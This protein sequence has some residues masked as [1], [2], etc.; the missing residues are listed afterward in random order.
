MSSLVAGP[1]LAEIDKLTG[2]LLVP[3]YLSSHINC[4]R[5]LSS[6][7]FL[8]LAF[9][10]SPLDSKTSGFLDDLPTL[11]RNRLGFRG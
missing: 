10:L 2:L 7:S 9:E 5:L 6:E 11:R 8:T 4:K 1:N 3:F